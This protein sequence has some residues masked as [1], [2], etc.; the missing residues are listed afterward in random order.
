MERPEWVPLV[1]VLSL[2]GMIDLRI[3]V[4]FAPPPTPFFVHFAPPTFYCTF[5][6][7]PPLKKRAQTNPS[8]PCRNLSK[9][10][11]LYILPPPH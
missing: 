9:I 10:K 1:R 5:C 6:P 8:N 3:N 7:P 11:Y 4:H 2:T